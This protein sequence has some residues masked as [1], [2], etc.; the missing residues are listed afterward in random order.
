LV[1]DNVSKQLE[2]RFRV[3]AG[4]VLLIFLALVARLWM[5]QIVQGATSMLRSINNQT[6][7]IRIA[8]PRGLFYDRNNQILVDSRISHNVLIAPKNIQDREKNSQYFK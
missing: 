2:P 5:L 3:L 6:A 7:R 8:A 4:V 1:K